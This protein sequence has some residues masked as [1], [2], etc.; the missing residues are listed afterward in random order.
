MLHGTDLSVVAVL[1][2][3]GAVELTWLVFAAWG[4]A[5]ITGGLVYGAA[6]KAVH[7]LWLLL[8]LAV[9]TAPIG[10]ASSPWL[11]CLAILPAVPCASR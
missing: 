3:A 8:V 1:R 9:L 5:S 4:S 7:P 11:L 6:P 10:L 2:D